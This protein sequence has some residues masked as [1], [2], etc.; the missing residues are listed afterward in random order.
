MVGPADFGPRCD[1]SGA[2]RIAGASLGVSLAEREVRSRA[3]LV[4]R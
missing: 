3:P 2:G 1:S 4:V